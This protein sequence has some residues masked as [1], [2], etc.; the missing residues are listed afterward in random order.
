M[1]TY[2]VT[3]G[4]GFIGSHL[5][6]RLME[7]DQEVL[8]ID[9]LSSGKERYL[10]RWEGH[11]R[12]TFSQQK[13]EDLTTIPHGFTDAKAIFHLA[14]LPSVR[15]GIDHPDVQWEKNVVATYHLLKAVKKAEIPYLL[16]SSS[17]TVYGDP[18]TL[19]TPETHLLEPISIYGS[20]KVAC[21]S[22][23]SGFAHTFDLRALVFR[24]ANIMGPRVNHGVVYDFVR[25]LE[26]TPE[27]LEI[28]GDGT[29]NKSYLHV[30]D[31]LDGIFTVFEAFQENG[32]AFEVYNIGNEGR[33]TVMRI[34]EIVSEEM[35]LTPEFHTTGGVKGGRG[36][37]G[38]VKEMLLDI[39]KITT[40]GW[41]P[42][43]SSEEAI[44]RTA[45]MLAEGGAGP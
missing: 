37:K 12:F 32:E 33:T 11:E 20:T 29:Q 6:D 25:K 10:R 42:K 17:S 9:D 3:G 22:L 8:V 23:I 4:A 18:Q 2:I 13:L 21:E 35:G 19:P 1:A 26:E 40:M 41:S 30:S 34:A 39:T 15:V 38:D 31:L 28:L 14:A 5:V 43:Y 36:W 16:F 27:K 44:R 24:F 7:N 45:R